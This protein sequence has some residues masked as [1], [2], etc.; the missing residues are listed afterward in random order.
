MEHNKDYLISET[1]RQDIH[2]HLHSQGNPLHLQNEGPLIVTSGEGPW[3]IDESGNRYLDGSAGLW[4]AALGFK[5]DRL[6]VAA[7]K[8]Y[9][10]LGCYHTFGNKTPAATAKLA[11]R[12]AG[13][14]PISD[15]HIHFSSSGSEGIETM[16]KLTWLYHKSR[17]NSGKRKIIARNRAFHGSTIFAASLSGLPHMHREFG[18]PLPGILH[19]SCPDIYR[20]LLNGESEAEYAKRLAN[21]LEQMIL[22]DGPENI[23]AFI[24]EPI[25]AGGGVIVPPAGY[26]EQIHNVLKRYDIL[27]L[28]DEIVCGFGRTGEWF[29][30]QTVNM[31]P[32]MMV[33][34]KGLSAGHFPISATVIS[35]RIHESIASIN[36]DGTN[37][38]HGFTNSG[39]PVGSAIA[40]E[41]LDIYEEMDVPNYASH[42]G[43]HLRDVLIE[44]TRN[45]GLVG[46]IRGAG[47]MIGV[48]LVADKSTRAPFSADKQVGKQFEQFALKQGL[49]IRSQGGDT[50]AFSPPL[51][52]DEPTAEEMA[53]RFCMALKALETS[54]T[55]NV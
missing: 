9:L 12:L 48:E 25:N 32:D 8:A 42:I 34:A 31:K 22:D 13:I 29:G 23:G 27:L 55:A 21:E 20:G 35:P 41:A 28:A 11:S 43:N 53:M 7:S 44:G 33:M 14:V 19:A 15:A 5:N 16:V 49:I 38:G 3:I 24:A 39:H 37:F 40:L 45:S 10:S 54:L 17:G 26:F 6:A 50:L 2:H 4:C 18:L 47:M 36:K 1:G 46:D 51:N 52:I 30:S